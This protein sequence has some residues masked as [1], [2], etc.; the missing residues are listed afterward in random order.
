MVC[1][2]AGAPD[3]R[4]APGPPTPGGARPVGR[5][6]TL[7]DHYEYGPIALALIK[8]AVPA[9]AKLEA[10]PMAAAID[11]DSLPPDDEPQAGRMAV[12]RLRG[13]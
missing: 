3:P 2:L 6:G 7:V 9:D 12:E 1:H 5:L 8:R 10:G 4:P 13:R 11:P